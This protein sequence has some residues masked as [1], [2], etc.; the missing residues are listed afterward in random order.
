MM[1]TLNRL[2]RDRSPREQWLLGIMFALLGTVIFWFALVL[3]IDSALTAARER[4][5]RAAL[6]AGQVA[7][8]V[9]TLETARRSPPPAL[10]A[11]LAVVVA[12]SA[13]EAGFTL[14]RTDA[15]G[16]DRVAIAI[17]AAK[18]PV[19]FTWLSALDRRGIFAE[20]INLR[21]GS[22]G[23]LAVDAVLRLK[24]L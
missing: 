5:D 17:P 11:P 7:A 1:D 14:D 4:L 20:S 6:D 24:R 23:S 2:W 19:L 15:Q 12:G 18:G 22:D 21:P 9:Q 16:D 13:Q 3:P 8:R 10:G